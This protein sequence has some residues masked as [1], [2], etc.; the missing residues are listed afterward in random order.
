[1]RMKYAVASFVA[2]FLAIGAAP[3]W[4]HDFDLSTSFSCLGSGCQQT[5]DHQE[6][7]P[8]KGWANITVLNTGTEA[9]G[10]FHF[11]IFETSG[12]S[13][14]NVDFIV[15][16]PYEPFSPTRPTLTWTVDNNAVG[17]TLDLFFYDN[18]VE[19]DEWASFHIYTDNTTDQLSYFFRLDRPGHQGKGAKGLSTTPATDHHTPRPRPGR[20]FLSLSPSGD[21][22]ERSP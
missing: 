4:G 14:E 21:V 8:F 10:D 7:E 3:A 12:G 19:V 6:A 22:G 9:W 18:P 11:E 17:A 15:A 16:T 13:V 20:R 1:M 5:S 2:V